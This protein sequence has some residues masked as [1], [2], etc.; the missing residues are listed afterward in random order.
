MLEREKSSV[1]FSVRPE[2]IRWT[3][4]H[5]LDHSEDWRSPHRHYVPLPA[6]ARSSAARIRWW[7]P[8]ALQ[9]GKQLPTA[10]ALDNVH[11][12]AHLSREVEREGGVT[13]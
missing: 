10:W 13:Q 7:Q 12:G 11:I 9:H 4:I 6:A 5:T 8:R 2:G 3:T 1:A